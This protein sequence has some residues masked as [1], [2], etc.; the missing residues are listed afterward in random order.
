L[1]SHADFFIWHDDDGIKHVSTHSPECQQDG[2][3]N[4]YQ[5]SP[6]TLSPARASVLATM[7]EHR[8]AIKQTDAI[9]KECVNL[10]NRRDKLE[11]EIKEYVSSYTSAGMSFG[12]VATLPLVVSKLRTKMFNVEMEY[13]KCFP[14]AERVRRKQKR[15]NVRKQIAENAK[16][17]AQ[18]SMKN[19]ISDIKDRLGI[20]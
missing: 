10:K 17:R 16:H 3:F 20:F 4:Y 12:E 11:D 5:C 18:I 7:Q 8:N 13:D 1:S 9:N 15:N 6:L 19:D 14:E 2:Y